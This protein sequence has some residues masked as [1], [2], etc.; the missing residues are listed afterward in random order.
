MTN[1]S[2]DNREGPF[3]LL[4]QLKDRSDVKP[5]PIGEWDIQPRVAFENVAE[6]LKYEAPGKTRGISAIP[7]MWARPLLVEMALHDGNHPL[8]QDMVLQWEGMLA[9]IG[10][11]QL[12]TFPLRACL[13]EIDRLE[14]QQDFAQALLSL[15]PT[16]R[17]HN[18]YELS[19]KPSTQDPNRHLNPWQD[20]YL[21]FWDSK[22]VGMTS[23]STLVVP[24]EEGDWGNLPWW[25]NQG[26]RSRLVSPEPYLS[27]EEKGLL[28]LWLSR[29]DAVL[30]SGGSFGKAGG[31]LRRLIRGFQDKLPLGN[32]AGQ[33]ADS[34]L[35]RGSDYFGTTIN[36]GC[37]EVLGQPIKAPDRPSSITL[38]VAAQERAILAPGKPSPLPLVIL[39]DGIVEQ[40]NI[41]P[42]NIAVHGGDTLASIAALS[43]DQW[44]KRQDS[45]LG[46]V[47]CV[48][49]DDLFLPKLTFIEQGPPATTLPAAIMPTFRDRLQFKGM[50][51]TPLVPVRTLLLDYF[52]PEALSQAVEFENEN[53]PQGP[54]VKVTLRLPLSGMD[55]KVRELKVSKIYALEEENAITEVPFL[56]IWPNFKTRSGTAGAGTDGEN[57]W[58]T[59]YGF[60]GDNYQRQTFQVHFPTLASDGYAHHEYEEGGQR[61]QVDRLTDFPSHVQCQ[62]RNRQLV[63]LILLKTPATITLTNTCRVGVDFGT[64]STHAYVNRGNT[65]EAVP[66]QNLSCSITGVLASDRAVTLPEFFIYPDDPVGRTLP[67]RTVLT[68]RGMRTNLAVDHH[69]VILDARYYIPD[70]NKLD[71]KAD[72]IKTGLKLDSRSDERLRRFFLM[73][74]LLEATANL[75]A[76]GVQAITWRASFPSAF[77]DKE[78]RF[79]NGLW[80]NI[81]EDL[82]RSTSV[83]HSLDNLSLETESLAAGRYFADFEDLDLV[84]TTCIDIGGG[85]SDISIWKGRE[86]IHQCSL[87]LAG[88][89]LFTGI[90]QRKPQFI[91]NNIIKPALG[92]NSS[93]VNIPA[94]ENLSPPSFN[95]KFDVLLVQHSETILKK[96]GQ[97][98]FENSQEFLDFITMVTL[99]FGGLFYYVGQVLKTLHLE[100]KYPHAEITPVYLGG[101]GSR[102]LNWLDPIG[103]FDAES[104]I[105]RLLSR[106]LNCGS[107][108]APIQVP[109]RLSKNPK[110][111]AACGLVQTQTKLTGLDK[112]EDSLVAGEIY[113]MGGQRRAAEGRVQFDPEQDTLASFAMAD[114]E[115]LP[116]FVYHFHEAIKDF[117][118]GGGI[119][120]YKR[121]PIPSDN[122]DLW[123]E[124]KR[125][126]D[127]I[128]LDIKQDHTTHANFKGEDI[129]LE[130]PFI[131][132]L[133]ALLQVLAERWSRKRY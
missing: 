111:E 16:A 62:D 52:T 86:L 103:Q 34:Y 74:F 65:L 72:Y 25:Q 31:R 39:D 59:Y 8:H 98:E 4:P 110:A 27:P 83:V 91:V 24:S 50:D 17:D 60:Y 49:K 96:R 78:C 123:R 47:R 66:F 48:T 109:T 128:L 67:I 43:P 20:L 79:Y 122:E 77:S 40:W 19:N 102:F 126:L 92:G 115:Q 63:G 120:G 132:G 21:W 114:L 104:D 3:L 81:L 61:F 23:P 22:P 38:R 41:P 10:L 18:L 37:L 88:R 113:T 125:K 35:V 26:D 93:L 94:W 101:N 82:N 36:R 28:H 112:S 117:K 64:S 73:N 108:F 121:S 90:L 12:R 55:G 14:N 1:S 99:G 33:G 6:S 105:N 119:A 45:W 56:E 100:D 44:Q 2:N 127:N 76:T 69:E 32:F 54:G 70:I 13:F 57:T 89:D 58:K 42:Q 97:P 129:R 7:T 124:V 29:I 53:T 131:L 130:P 30:P 75:A 5:G 84:Q 85:T 9:A 118:L 68:T 51:I 106:M 95:L 46:Q 133:K 80:K 15:L 116:Q 71:V 11:A 107:G 87:Q